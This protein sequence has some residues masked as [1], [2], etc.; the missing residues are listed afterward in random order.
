[1]S[2]RR[3]FAVEKLLLSEIPSFPHAL[4][5]LPHSPLDMSANALAAGSTA[6]AVGR[7]AVL[8]SF[9]RAA[10]AAAPRAPAAR[11]RHALS[12]HADERLNIVFVGAECAPFSKT[13][14]LGDVMASL[15]KVR[16]GSSPSRTASSRVLN[17][18]ASATARLASLR[19]QRQKC[20]LSV[21]YPPSRALLSVIF[22]HIGTLFFS[23]FLVKR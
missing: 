9:R 10:R 14:G 2:N 16:P 23:F 18:S 22:S 6:P 21:Y 4:R 12:V 20:Q 15:P 1:M 11:G 13:G 5:S 3:R 8:P 19:H 17:A 7:R